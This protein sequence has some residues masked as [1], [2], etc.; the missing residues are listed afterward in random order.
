M[1]RPA[2]VWLAAAVA[3][4]CGKGSEPPQARTSEPAAPTG[5]KPAAKADP[6]FDKV[7]RP[8]ATPICQQARGSFGY[9]AACDEIEL[10]E[11]ETAA[12]KVF[13]VHAVDDPT[14]ARLYALVRPSGEIVVSRGGSYSEVLAAITRSLDLRATPPETLALLHATLYTESA[15]VRCLPGDALPTD[16][17]KVYRAGPCEPP[18]IVG[19]GDRTLL[20]YVV[21]QWPDPQLMN[22][23]ER[24][25]SFAKVELGDGEL[26]FKEADY[27]MVLD[28][29]AP[30][31][32]GL[33][34]V[35]TMTS[36]PDWVGAPVAAA[37]DVS[38]A[39]CAEARSSVSRLA[40]QRCEAFGYPSLEL[41][42]GSIYY[43]ANDAGERYAFALRKP[44]GAIVAG[45][46]VGNDENPLSPIVRGY[47]PAVVPAD[48]FLA[49][50]LLLTGKPAQILCL[51]GSGDEIPDHPCEPPTAAMDGEELV[52]KAILLELPIPGDR[53]VSEPAVR[54]VEWRFTPRGGMSG[55]GFRLVDLREDA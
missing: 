18:A 19:D 33:P 7:K 22:R 24:R 31:P 8:P 54:K 3:V 10:P 1:L 53:F 11:L 27:L 46:A 38:E 6:R 32:P 52:V 47:D 12:G 43:L 14:R 39:L 13:R 16:A 2:G 55:D 36:P 15:I 29:A 42:T 37:A 28:P 51:P 44:D 17:V 50:Y 21:E 35:P 30:R 49:A 20:T 48:K 34:P 5:S 9:A 26:S 41:P 23:D 45:Y 40:G 4:G 25:I